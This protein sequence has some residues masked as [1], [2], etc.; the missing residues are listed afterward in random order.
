MEVVNFFRD[1]EETYDNKDVVQQKDAGNTMDGAF[2]Q[3]GSFN[4]HAIKKGPN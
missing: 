1:E 4:Y 3:R 2:K